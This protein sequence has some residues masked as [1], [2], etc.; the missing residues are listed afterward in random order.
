MIKFNPIVILN[1]QSSNAVKGKGKDAFRGIGAV[2]YQTVRMQ[3]KGSGSHMD[4][5]P[6][7]PPGLQMSIIVPEQ[8]RIPFDG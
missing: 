7:F 8:D 1:I 3:V 5:I 4:K 6:E 2:K